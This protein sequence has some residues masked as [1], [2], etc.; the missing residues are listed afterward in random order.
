MIMLATEE[1]SVLD[2]GY[3][4]S[5]TTIYG[6]GGG[7]GG[8]NHGRVVDI[9]NVS[10]FGE[11]GSAA[12]E[13]DECGNAELWVEDYGELTQ[14]QEVMVPLVGLLDVLESLTKEG[15]LPIPPVGIVRKCFLK[16]VG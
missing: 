7:R 2:K 4:I 1:T 11:R 16:L 5:D 13:L 15:T 6:C 8:D 10:V 3:N 14:L 9:L 12:A